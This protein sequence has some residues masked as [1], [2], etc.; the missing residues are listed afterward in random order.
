L[1]LF[2]LI[3]EELEAFVNIKRLLKDIFSEMKDFLN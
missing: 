1:R 2:K 3:F